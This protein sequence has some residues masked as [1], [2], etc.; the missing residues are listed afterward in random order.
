MKSVVILGAGFSGTMVAVQLMKRATKPMQLFLVERNEF[1]R[2]PAYAE[3][4][5]TLLLNV[6]ADQMGAFP[7]RVDHFY[8]WLNSKNFHAEPHEFISRK[9]YGD[10]LEDLLEE[11]IASSKGMVN[12]KLI[13]DEVI[14]IT[15]DRKL[16]LLSKN[17]P[18]YFD[19]LVLATG[20]TPSIDSLQKLNGLQGPITIF[21]SGLS[22][23]DAI[24]T[25][26]NR[27][28]NSKITVVSRRGLLPQTHKFFAENEKRPDYK[29]LKLM[30]LQSLVNFVRSESK[31]Y[32]WRLVIDG[33]RPHTQQLWKHFSEKEKGQFLRYLRPYWESHRHRIPPMHDKLLHELMK[34]GQLEVKAIGFKPYKI[35]T[36]NVLRCE[37]LSLLSNHII[38]KMIAKNVVKA[39]DFNL[40]VSTLQPWAHTIGALRRGEL[41][42]STAVSE[43]RVQA[44]E[45]AV[46]LLAVD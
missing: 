22:M 9:I 36:K 26:V 12:V 44:Q 20:L 17:L 6:R 18:V 37:G 21:G 2:G 16:L 45:L 34:K 42:E 10:Y 7:D 40:G 1:G 24:I 5:E 14:N 32:D 27:N 8:D 33:L 15:P 39:D 35:T 19:E 23:V 31:K 29:D 41:W 30:S 25:L 38:T 43:L 3:A 13:K 28:F 4:D 11:A 46:Q